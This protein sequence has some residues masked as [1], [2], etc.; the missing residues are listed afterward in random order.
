[1]ATYP[2]KNDS[3]I[4]GT[5][6]WQNTVNLQHWLK[7]RGVYAKA[8]ECDGAWGYWTTLGIQTYLRQ[9]TFPDGTRYYAG[10]LDGQFGSMTKKAM[11]D[12]AGYLLSVGGVNYMYGLC[13]A[14]SCTVS[15]PSTSVVKQWQHFLNAN[16]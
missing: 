3:N 1:M 4:D 14:Y 10:Q 12:A 2:P 7:A 11:G 6:S 16:T 5:F 13:S 8:R 9:R 15:W